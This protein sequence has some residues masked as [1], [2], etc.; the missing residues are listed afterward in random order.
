[1]ASVRE[2]GLVPPARLELPLLDPQV[3]GELRI[4]AS[5]LL[6]E[7]LG[8]LAFDLDPERKS[9]ESWLSMTA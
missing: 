7:A 3:L 6:D 5:D 1:V 8:V 9:G 4:V 2:I